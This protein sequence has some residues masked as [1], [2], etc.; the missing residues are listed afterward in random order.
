MF[1]MQ[2]WVEGR[3][4]MEMMT[5][6]NTLARLLVLVLSSAPAMRCFAVVIRLRSHRSEWIG[7][8]GVGA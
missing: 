5:K 2:R 3:V 7:R 4:R 6:R 8:G 1:G